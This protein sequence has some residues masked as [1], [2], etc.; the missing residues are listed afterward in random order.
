MTV[1]LEPFVFCTHPHA[2]RRVRIDADPPNYTRTTT[3]LIAYNDST[4]NALLI[5]A[6]ILQVNCHNILSPQT[7]LI[8]GKKTNPK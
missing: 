8:K 3:G 6:E 2:L 4:D 5:S 1:I 7:E